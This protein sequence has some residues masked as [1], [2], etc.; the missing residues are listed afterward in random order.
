MKVRIW[1]TFMNHTLRMMV[2]PFM[3]IYFA[4]RLGASIAGAVIVSFIIVGLIS[5]IIGGYLS[6]RLGRRQ[7]MIQAEIVMLLGYAGMMLFNSPW[8]DSAWMTFVM[9]IIISAAGGIHSPANQAMLVDVT[10]PHTRKY[11]YQMMYWLRNIASAFAAVIGAYLF[12]DYFFEL[13]VGL[14]IATIL[15]ILITYFFIQE[16]YFPNKDIA[17]DQQGF[18]AQVAQMGR[19]YAEV[20]KDSTFVIFI[21]S[22]M[23]VVSVEFHLSNYVGVRLSQ[24]FAETSVF[25]W[26]SFNWTIDGIRMMGLLQAENT[27]IIGV[28]SIMM[29]YI[30]KNTSEKKLVFYGYL[31]YVLGYS[32]IAY[33]NSLWL[34][35]IAM[36]LA[37]IGE[38]C[39]VSVRQAYFSYITPDHARS[40]YLAVNDMS[41]QVAMFL[42]GAM[43]SL[44]SVLPSIVMA[45]IIGSLG[46]VGILLFAIILP[47]LEGKRD[48]AIGSNS[49]SVSA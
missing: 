2:I 38:M 20:L 9:M 29:G 7:L 42:A 43:V 45:G 49:T 13:L 22:T 34:L 47:R 12:R 30:L 15:S 16:S 32:F 1:L 4:E 6:D 36:L 46:L 44:G 17:Q 48:A 14:N 11:M 33:S 24:E 27:I 35:I 23:L 31:V 10:E 37:T 25:S 40:S 19:N 28:F 41:F 26:G 5:S 18:I 3:A 21:T 8:L 39:S